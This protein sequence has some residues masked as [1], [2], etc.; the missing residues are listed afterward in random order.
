MQTAISLPVIIKP[1]TEG[2]GRRPSNTMSYVPGGD[3]NKLTG[4]CESVLKQIADRIL[5]DGV[6]YSITTVGNVILPAVAQTVA[7]CPG[8][9]WS[10]EK[11]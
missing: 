6:E 9:H 8:S 10:E 4:A 3:W 7:R 5:L 11:N 1:A 2:T